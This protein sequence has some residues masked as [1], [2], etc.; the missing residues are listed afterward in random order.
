MWARR[1]HFATPGDESRHV[2]Q[3]DQRRSRAADRRVRVTFPTPMAPA[4]DDLLAKSGFAF[5]PE[6]WPSRARLRIFHDDGMRFSGRRAWE[7]PGLVG[8]GGATRASGDIMEAERWN[9]PAVAAMRA[10]DPEK[11]GTPRRLTMVAAAIATGSACPH[12]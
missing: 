1:P 5:P 4:E 7:R 6:G 11:A 3:R 12:G 9:Q 10:V 8:P 2:A